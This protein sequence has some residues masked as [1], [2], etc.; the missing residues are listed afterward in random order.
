[1]P[2]PKLTQQAYTN[3]GGINLKVTPEMNNLTEFLDLTN[4]DFI[5]PGGLKSRDGTGSLSFSVGS[6]IN[7]IQE[8][9][10]TNG[11]SALCF[12]TNA[13][14]YFVQAA[15][16]VTFQS[17]LSGP[18]STDF[19][20]NDDRIWFAN[21]NNFM[22]FK[23]TTIQI[24]VDAYTSTI[25]ESYLYGLQAPWKGNPTLGTFGTPDPDSLNAYVGVTISPSGTMQFSR[26]NAGQI[27]LSYKFG[28]VNERGFHGP[29]DNREFLVARTGTSVALAFEHFSGSSLIGFSDY[30]AIP[31]SYGIGLSASQVTD[32][33]VGSVPTG[34]IGYLAVYRAD[35]PST[36]HFRIGYIGTDAIE[37]TFPG[38]T[39]LTLLATNFIRFKDQA[40]PLSTFPEPTNIWF[41][42]SPQYIEAYNN[43]FFMAGFSGFPNVCWFSDIGEPESVDATFNFEVQTND[44]DVITCLKTFF[45]TLMIFKETSFHS[46]RGND[47]SNFTVSEISRDYGCLNNKSATN[48]TNYLV[49]LDRKG[50]FRYTGAQIECLSDKVEPI[51]RRMNLS[52]C[53]QNSYVVHDKI[54]NQL[55]VGLALDSSTS[56][57]TVMVYD[58]LLGA[59]TKEEGN[60]FSAVA[61]AKTNLQNETVF[62]GGLSGSIRYYSPSFISDVGSGLTLSFKTIFTAGDQQSVQKNFRQLFVNFNPAPSSSNTFTIEFFTDYNSS[63]IV[64]T[65]YMEQQ[66]F[67]TR[68][69]FGYSAKSLSFRMSTFTSSDV[70]AM[71]GY[72]IAHKFL[73]EV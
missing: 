24:G 58:Y 6:T 20:T 65:R 72:T 62:F 9:I 43:Q 13:N 55:K 27:T 50:L 73:R 14:A 47:I 59:W 28:F 19:I 1:M 18:L 11:F 4:Y 44:G 26:W 22:K 46:L 37:H 2:Y 67:Q 38:G 48:Y 32:L 3:F 69:D 49:F 61:I 23:G 53:R 41:T 17:G 60:T 30:I 36:S 54:K 57:N 10:K 34:I 16:A 71:H 56:I 68:L 7:G 63:T 25:F 39:G 70:V 15:Q 8:F 21:G 66:L 5:Q 64:D 29:T 33:S 12:A 35:L 52:A 51:F 31:A 42:L 40:Y 45:N